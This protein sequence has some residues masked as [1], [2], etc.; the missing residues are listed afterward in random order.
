MDSGNEAVPY[1]KINKLLWRWKRKDGARVVREA[2]LSMDKAPPPLPAPP[3]PPVTKAPNPTPPKP[4][5][6]VNVLDNIESMAN[7]FS[8]FKTWLNT[9][10]PPK[11]P[12]P[13]KPAKK[14]ETVPPFDI[15]E[16]PGAMRKELMPVSAKLMERWF[17]GRLNYSPTD[18]EES[19]EID[20]EGKPYPPDMYDMTT[21]KL[22]WVLRHERASAQYD[23]LQ[24]IERLTTPRAIEALRSK[25]APHRSSYGTVD[26]M[27][28]CNG[29]MKAL[30]K[31]F[32]FQFAGVES[33]LTQKFE[34]YITR[35]FHSNGVPDDLTGALG[36]FNFYAAIGN[37]NFNRDASRATISTIITYVKDNYTFTD[38]KGDPSQYLGHWNRRGVIIV[39]A[40]G[41]A[42]IAGIRWID[43][44]V[45]IGDVRVRDNVYYPVRNSSFR[46][47]QRRHHRGGDFVAY[48]D[49]RFIKLHQPIEIRFL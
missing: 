18:D 3:E 9:P 7:T 39:P 49:Y 41:A 26:A 5:P 46:E 29:D 47:W 21:V 40:T 35:Y 28:L 23:A 8:R 19:L 44:P 22:D 6:L 13:P 36:S 1:H 20:Q 30:H 14:V 32:Q 38:K 27:T 37:A 31:N 34:Q 16:I 24:R 2:S 33:T 17:A 10:E 11:P 42:G 4:D 15:Q 48:S 45:A 43:Y 25:L 12:P